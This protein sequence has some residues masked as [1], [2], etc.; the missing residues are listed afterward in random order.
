MKLF[1]AAGASSL[2]PHILLREAGLPFALEKVDL[3]TKRWSGGDFNATNPKSYVPVLQMEDGD[4]FTECAVI[5][6]FVA[7]LRPERGL[8]PAPGLR[9]RYQALEWLNFIGMEIHKNFITP[10]RHGGV[11]A[12]FLSKTAEGQ[13][14]TRVRVAPRLAYVDEA[15][16][17]RHYLM[18]SSFTA[19]DAYLFTMLT[20]A[21]RLDLDLSLWHTL[22][23]YSERIASMPSVREALAIEGPPHSLKP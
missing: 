10:E 1:Y 17:G 12:N 6:Q 22:S 13:Q 16:R 20:W 18:G 9:S 14:A 5:L 4:T 11:S 15:L 3:M 7:D 21:R 8:M 23:D 2:A 19:P